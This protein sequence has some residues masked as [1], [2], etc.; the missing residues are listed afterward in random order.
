M[1]TIVLFNWKK[2]YFKILHQFQNIIVYLNMK[3]VVFFL[4]CRICMFFAEKWGKCQ[5]SAEIQTRTTT[6]THRP[7]LSFLQTHIRQLSLENQLIFS[8]LV[9][10]KHIVIKSVFLIHKSKEN[11]S[12]R[13]IIF[14]KIWNI[15]VRTAT[16]EK[17]CHKK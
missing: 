17:N 10:L 3:M 14:N 9:G 2:N 1:L 11:F 7:S 15:V 4:H 5:C 6:I 16:Y 8:T 13:N 12:I